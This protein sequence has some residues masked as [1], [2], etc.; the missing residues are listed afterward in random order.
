LFRILYSLLRRRIFPYPTLEELRQ[1]R[2]ERERAE[3][4]GGVL[5]S[6]LNASSS[7]GVKELWRIYKVVHKGK[8]TKI[9]K[10]FNKSQPNLTDAPDEATVL[11][12]EVETQQERDVKRLVLLILNGFAD[13][14]ERLKK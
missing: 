11:D 3:I 6:R 10:A 14:H 2:G 5:S 7:V 8:R 12:D 13:L 4:F 1:R 9:K